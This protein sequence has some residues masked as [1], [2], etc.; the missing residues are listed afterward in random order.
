MF[1][2]NIQRVKDNTD[3]IIVKNWKVFS[4]LSG[5]QS[6]AQC[7]FQMLEMTVVPAWNR[8][9]QL[10]E[11]NDQ[12][13]SYLLLVCLV[14]IQKLCIH[15]FFG[16]PETCC[17]LPPGACLEMVKHWGEKNTSSLPFKW[18]GPQIC[19]NG[20]FSLLAEFGQN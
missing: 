16:L 4:S 6:S 1:L 7:L 19:Y 8:L 10:W 2:G 15:T 14:F 9:V 11:H 5:E 13:S 20:Y 12:D 3:D 18:Y 17:I